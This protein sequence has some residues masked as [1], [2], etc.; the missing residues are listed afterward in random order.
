[1]KFPLYSGLAKLSHLP[2]FK[3]NEDLGDSFN[4]RVGVYAIVFNQLTDVLALNSSLGYL[5]PGGGVDDM[6]GLG[7]KLPLSIFYGKC[8]ENLI[9]ELAEEI[10]ED[11]ARYAKLKMRM[12]ESIQYFYS[13]NTSKAIEMRC[14]FYTVESS[15]SPDK[16]SPDNTGDIVW[17]PAPYNVNWFH[18]SQ[19]Y[20]VRVAKRHILSSKRW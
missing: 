10:G 18:K 15:A 5:L 19:E 13:P 1:M 6:E 8:K 2:V 17:V 4:Q 3:Q 11:F 12:F 7:V 9:R 14:V 20:A 16:E